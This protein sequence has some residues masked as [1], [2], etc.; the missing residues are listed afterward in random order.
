MGGEGIAQ[1]GV[2]QWP[3]FILVKDSCDPGK[4]HYSNFRSWGK[5]LQA[6]YEYSTQ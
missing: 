3:D 6:P 1:K 4:N 5:W 2:N